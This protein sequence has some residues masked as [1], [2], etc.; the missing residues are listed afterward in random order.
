M[1]I[2]IE[3]PLKGFSGGNL[4]CH[5]FTFSQRGRPGGAEGATVGSGSPP[6]EYFQ[7]V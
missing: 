7:P 6:R 3:I 5:K 1:V 4:C 2:W